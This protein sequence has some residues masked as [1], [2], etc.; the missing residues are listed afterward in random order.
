M[1]TLTAGRECDALVAEKVM[2][3]PLTSCRNIHWPRPGSGI[4]LRIPEFSKDTAAAHRVLEKF[5]GWRSTKPVGATEYTVTVEH[6]GSL[7][8]ATS[9]TF[10][11][12]ACLAAL[13]A[14]GA[15]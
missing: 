12:A 8:W 3:L 14:E 13:R 1:S 10:A 2:G 15:A 7:Y 6:N 4:W 11:H 5:D 9:P